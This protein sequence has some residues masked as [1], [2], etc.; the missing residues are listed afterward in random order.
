MVLAM[1]PGRTMV[2]ISP[3]NPTNSK[4]NIALYFFFYLVERNCNLSV[5][6]CVNTFP[7]RCKGMLKNLDSGSG[8]YF[9]HVAAHGTH[10]YLE[11]DM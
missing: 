2:S 6:Q 5:F 3:F 1:G 11:F 10:D 4:A 8:H 7:K 9:R